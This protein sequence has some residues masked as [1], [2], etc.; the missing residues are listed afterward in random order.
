MNESIVYLSGHSDTVQKYPDPID[1]LKKVMEQ[2][3][4]RNKDLK[5]YIGSSGNVCSVLKKRKPELV[6]VWNGLMY[7]RSMFVQAAK[8]LGQELEVLPTPHQ[9]YT[10]FVVLVVVEPSQPQPAQ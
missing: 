8:E 9:W 5:A 6:V 3:N 10:H 7:R 1:Y 2:R 4:M